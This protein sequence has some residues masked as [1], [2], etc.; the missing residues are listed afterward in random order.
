MRREPA[1]SNPAKPKTPGRLGGGPYRRQVREKAGRRRPI[2]GENGVPA[3]R[4]AQIES[5]FCHLSPFQKARCRKG[6]AVCGRARPVLVTER[7]CAQA[8][9]AEVASRSCHRWGDPVG[10]A[11]VRDQKASSC[12]EGCSPV[13]VTDRE[14]ATG[15]RV[16]SPDPVLV[17]DYGFTGILIRIADQRR[18]FPRGV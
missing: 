9:P 18:R 6:R 4:S 7:L 12:C 15:R 13:L 17:A 11:G 10:P 5:R 2:S 3:R 8:L 16:V 14:G 1:R